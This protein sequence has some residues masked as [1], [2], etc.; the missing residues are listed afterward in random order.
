MCTFIF[1]KNYSLQN[2]LNILQVLSDGA[3]VFDRKERLYQP[4]TFPSPNR[5]I[6]APFL[7][8]HDPRSNGRVHYKVYNEPTRNMEMVETF[9]KHRNATSAEFT[10]SWMLVAEWK[11]VPMSPATE[12]TNEV[13][14]HQNCF[15][16]CDE[17]SNVT[18]T[19]LL[20]LFIAP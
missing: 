12:P 17:T 14:F 15:G 16:Y 11:D 1:K 20:N 13:S 9:L 4:Q 2:K 3:I 6:V 18:S 7:T 8:D 10:G 19:H 5:Q